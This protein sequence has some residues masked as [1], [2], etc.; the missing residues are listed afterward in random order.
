[1][2]LTPLGYIG[3]LRSLNALFKL[4]NEESDTPHIEKK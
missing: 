1:M 2:Q 3:T 4:N